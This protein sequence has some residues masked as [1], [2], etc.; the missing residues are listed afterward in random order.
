MNI[1]SIK[2]F[3]LFTKNLNE[4]LESCPDCGGRIYYEEV[5]GLNKC[6]ECEWNEAADEPVNEEAELINKIYEYANLRQYSH[7]DEMRNSAY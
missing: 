2:S 5:L 1:K 7:I 6:N 3:E 4:N